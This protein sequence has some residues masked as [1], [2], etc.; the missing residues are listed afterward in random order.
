VEVFEGIAFRG[1]SSGALQMVSS[2]CAN[3]GT[4]G[5]TAITG[6]CA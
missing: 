5:T 4:A 2:L 3:G 6:D 1:F